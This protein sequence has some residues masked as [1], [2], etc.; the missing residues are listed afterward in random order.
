MMLAA[1]LLV[2][3]SPPQDDDSWIEIPECGIEMPV[4]RALLDQAHH[5][6][7]T[8]AP[9]GVAVVVADIGTSGTAALV[10]TN[11]GW[12]AY[13]VLNAGRIERVYVS[14]SGMFV[15]WAS[16]SLGSPPPGFSGVSISAKGEVSCFGEIAA[17]KELDPLTEPM[18][19][20]SFYLADHSDTGL[21]TVTADVERGGK[22]QQL[23]FASRTRDGGR[24]WSPLTRVASK[25][26][27]SSSFGE[28]A[29]ADLLI[30]DAGT[31][32]P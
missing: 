27:V 2:A 26:L 22:P 19:F 29:S 32:L 23:I 28:V 3:A 24:H 21:V 7:A 6:V 12:R 31:A 15:A 9:S 25:P 8:S 5:A 1:L 13:G 10:R 16:M 11:G 30:E 4:T 18:S 20:D 14:P 17:P